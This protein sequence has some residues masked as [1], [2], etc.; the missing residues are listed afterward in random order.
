[1]IWGAYY[2]AGCSEI[3]FV[4]GRFT[5]ARYLDILENKF[6]P[7]VYFNHGQEVNDFISMQEW[8]RVLTSNIVRNCLQDMVIAVLSSA[9]CS[10][11]LS[12]ME[13]CG[14]TTQH[15]YANS[16]HLCDLTDRRAAVKHVW[17]TMPQNELDTLYN[18]M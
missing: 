16:R 11:H 5:S 1:M 17:Y 2:S 12:P 10:H 3:C 15:V 4:E 6:V 14:V 9:A 8:C 18:S 7:H 13:N